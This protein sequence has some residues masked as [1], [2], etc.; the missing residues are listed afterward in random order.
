MSKPKLITHLVAER[1]YRQMLVY[2]EDPKGP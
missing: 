2:E 1:S